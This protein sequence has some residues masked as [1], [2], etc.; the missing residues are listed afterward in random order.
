LRTASRSNGATDDMDRP[1]VTA[2][3]L[4]SQLAEHRGALDQATAHLEKIQSRQDIARIGVRQAALMARQ[5]KMDEALGLIRKLPEDDPESAKNK[6]SA[7]VQLL[8]DHKQFAEAYK[9]LAKGVTRFPD[10]VDLQYDLAM[11]AERVGALDEMERLIRQIIAVK[12]DY[13]AAYNALGYSLADRN[14]RLDEARLLINKALEFAPKDP[15]ILDSLAWLEF[16]SGNAAQA[17]KLLQS[18]FKERP[19]AE[20]AAHL[21]E[22][23][24]SLTQREE[25]IAVWKEGMRLNP[26]NETLLETTKRLRGNQ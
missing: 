12:P 22:V 11:L 21:G 20:I 7:E 1:L 8:R 14:I 23:L 26:A 4:M 25:A 6:L 2:Y 16:R 3:M 17:V 5:G 18:A 15:F 13:H 9:V 19:D 24:W 10:D